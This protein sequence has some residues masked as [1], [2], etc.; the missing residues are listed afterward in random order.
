MEDIQSPQRGPGRPSPKARSYRDGQHFKISPKR[1]VAVF[2]LKFIRKG[3]HLTMAVTKLKIFTKTVKTLP[4]R[5]P[6]YCAG[7]LVT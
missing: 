6:S 4:C 7:H 1:S 5:S 2:T 3:H